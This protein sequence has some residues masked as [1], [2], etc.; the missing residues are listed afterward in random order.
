MNNR[1]VQTYRNV[2]SRLVPEILIQTRNFQELQGVE[3]QLRKIGS[4]RNGSELLARIKMLSTEGRHVQIITWDGNNCV[5]GRMTDKQVQATG[6]TPNP[7]DP[8][9]I[10]FMYSFARIRPDNTNNFGVVGIIKLNLNQ[11]VELDK[12]GFPT[13]RND[14]KQ[15]NFLSLAHELVHAYHLMNGT[16]LTSDP[17][18]TVRLI[19]SSMRQE[20]DRA[21]GMGRFRGSAISENGVRVD[22]NR[23]L[24]AHYFSL[25]Q[26]KQFGT[27]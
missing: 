8:L 23:P 18:E 5:A 7:D 27:Y 19:N 13:G 16:Y 15:D 11:G 24:R 26:I 20:E 14:Y 10:S 6:I 21:V 12:W 2:A 1:I 22:H 25:E 17:I 3:S 4:G 9:H